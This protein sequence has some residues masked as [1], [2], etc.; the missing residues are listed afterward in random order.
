MRSKILKSLAVITCFAMTILVL[1]GCSKADK[2]GYYDNAFMTALEKGLVARWKISDKEDSK[3]SYKKAVQAELDSV[4]EYQDK[5]F[6]NTQL[7]AAALDYINGLK[8]Q[9]SVLKYWGADDFDERWSAA[10][11]KRTA[12]LVAINKIHKIKVSEKQDN[13]SELLGNGK[14]VNEKENLKKKLSSKRYEHTIGVEYTSTCLAM[15]YG[16]DI[17]KARIAGLLHDC[18]KYLSSEDKISKCESYGIPV[19]DYERKNPELLHAKLGACFA[20]EIYGVTD[21]EI[22]SAIIWHTTGCPDMSLLDKIV[23]IADYIEANRDKAED[24]PKVRELAFKDIDACLLLILEDTIA[25][26]ARKKS[27]TDPMTQK[28]YDYYKERN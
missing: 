16:V 5:K 23:F 4:E 8:E 14:S 27:V 19:S 13:L 26:L 25:Y 21:S 10:Y 24:L 12:A 15:R 22:L 20:N 7:K 28:T 1:V 17:E 2:D 11:D 3:S 18:A 9:K 6:K